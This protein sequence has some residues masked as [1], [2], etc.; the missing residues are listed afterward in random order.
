MNKE[1]CL[2]FDVETSPNVSYTWHGKF[3][4]N[5]IEFVEEGGIISVAWKW[6]GEKKINSVCLYDVKGNHRKLMVLLRELFDEADIVIGHNSDSFDIRNANREFLRYGIT[7]PSPYKKVDTLKMAKKYFY[8]NS[9][10][11]NDIGKYLGIGEKVETGGF[12]LWK[13]CFKNNERS[14]WEKMKRYNRGDVELLEKVYLKLR[15]FSETHP[16][17]VLDKN[18]CKICGSRNLIA[19]GWKKM[20]KYKRRQYQCKDCGHWGCGEEKVLINKI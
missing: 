1:K 19:Q 8:L 13:R 20:V 9:N 12:D 16:N 10:R 3:E 18:V 5:V 15:P 17:I 2:L 14:A 7:P 4:Q 6:L 11:L